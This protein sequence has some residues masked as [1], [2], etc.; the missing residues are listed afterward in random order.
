MDYKSRLE[1]VKKPFGF[2]I[3]VKGLFS[4]KENDEN[5]NDRPKIITF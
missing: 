3:S 1:N 4:V 2:E 5:L